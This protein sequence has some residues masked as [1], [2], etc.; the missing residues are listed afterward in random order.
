MPWRSTTVAE[1]SAQLDG[2][3]HAVRARRGG[4]S[5]RSARAPSSGRATSRCSR[6][7]TRR[8]APRSPT[9]GS[10]RRGRTGRGRDG[11]GG[12]DA[13]RAR[14][15]GRASRRSRRS[16]RAGCG[17]SAVTTHNP[18]IEGSLDELQLGIG[19]VLH[20]EG[21]APALRQLRRGERA[22][23]G[24]RRWRGSASRS[25][26]PLPV[27]VFALGILRRRVRAGAAGDRVRR[28]LWWC[29][30]WAGRSIS[31]RRCAD[32]NWPIVL[33]LVAMLPLGEAVATTGAASTI[34]GG[35]DGGAARGRRRWWRRR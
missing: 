12:G 20:L 21:E 33:L 15:W 32:L 4:M 26:S 19:D 25:F 9:A 3:V 17:S 10:P 30:P 11:R 35:D 29:W 28:R 6:P 31:G 23:G 27:V 2:A 1:L 14:S 16:P 18:R 7:T 34:A 8:S 22:D 13:A 5:S 24:S